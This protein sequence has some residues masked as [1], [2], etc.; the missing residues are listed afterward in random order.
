MPVHPVKSFVQKHQTK[1]KTASA[2]LI[3]ANLP[4]FIAWN[5]MQSLQSG[6]FY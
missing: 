1:A 6:I 5:F 2:Q 3:P 4:I